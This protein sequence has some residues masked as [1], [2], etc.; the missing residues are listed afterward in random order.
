[1]NPL[2]APGN[3]RLDEKTIGHGIINS[4]PLRIEIEILRQSSSTTNGAGYAHAANLS[5]PNTR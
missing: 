3:A 2:V 4:V 5:K 1:M